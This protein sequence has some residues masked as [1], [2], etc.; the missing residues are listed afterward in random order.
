MSSSFLFDLLVT[1]LFQV[2][3]IEGQT[4]SKLG[5]FELLEVMYSRLSKEEV[6]SKNSK[7]NDVY[8]KGSA[9]SG[10]EMTQAITK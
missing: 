7:I 2:S 5:C 10:K 4:T 8:C 9:D 1:P 3:E 6:N